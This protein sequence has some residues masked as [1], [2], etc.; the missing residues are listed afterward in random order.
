MF[1]IEAVTEWL[2]GYTEYEINVGWTIYGPTGKRVDVGSR[3]RFPINSL[4]TKLGATVEIHK[5]IF[6]P[7]FYF[8]L[9]NSKTIFKDYD[10]YKGDMGQKTFIFGDA[11]NN[12]NLWGG[13]INL[14]Y[15]LQLSKFELKPQIEFS[16]QRMKF[17]DENLHQTNY[18]YFD[19]ESRIWQ[20]NPPRDTSIAGPVLRYKIDYKLLYLGGSMAYTAPFNLKTELTAMISPICW[21]H[22]QDDHLLRSKV[23]KTSSTGHAGYFNLKAAYSPG[24]R[25]TFYTGISYSFIKTSG[26]QSQHGPDVGDITG[27]PATTKAEWMSINVG[28]S[29]ALSKM[30]AES[31]VGF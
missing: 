31:K 10:W 23:S 27:I 5:F 20:C 14:G 7:H 9:H 29:F 4:I 1:S 21:A 2:D 25:I 8:Q 13:K 30:S 15:R 6:T 22:D 26:D 18:G 11:T 16:Y 24:S 19:N 3:L 28:A 12:A 17:D